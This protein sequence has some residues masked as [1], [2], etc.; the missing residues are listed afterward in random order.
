MLVSAVGFTLIASALGERSDV[1]V[2]ARDV[3][4]GHVLEARDLRSVQVAAEG[5]VV[6]VADRGRVVGRQTRVPL[7]R[8]SLLSRG[9][10]GERA[11]F[12]PKGQSEV[13]LAVESGGAS[14]EL[15]RGQ[16]VAVLP[17]PSGLGAAKEG[18]GEG[19][20][21]APGA[22]VGTVTGVKAS[23]SAGGPRVVTVLTE[24]GAIRRAAGLEHPRV[25]VLPAQGREAP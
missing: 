1:L 25:V 10:F 18:E 6:P 8:G 21:K 22:V 23:E 15:A 20:E 7:V 3:P 11:V 16:R 17:G 9:Q 24:T 19:E 13:A 12:P 14:P 4:A 2:V 5:G